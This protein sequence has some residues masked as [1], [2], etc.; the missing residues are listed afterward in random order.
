MAYISIAD[1]DIDANSPITESLMTA[2]RDNPFQSDSPLSEYAGASWEALETQAASGSSSLDFT[3]GTWSLYQCVVFVLTGIVP[4]AN[5]QLQVRTST[6]GGSTWDSGTGNYKYL[7]YGYASALGNVA[8][9]SASATEIVLHANNQHTSTDYSL[10]G[11]LWLMNPSG[12][13]YTNCQWQIDLYDSSDYYTY[14]YGAGVRLSAADV[15]GLRFLPTSG[16]IAQ[17]TV[18]S[19]GLVLPS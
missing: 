13:N 14:Q 10:N 12:T 11:A 8:A 2:L 19:Y 5:S 9:S 15:D 7:N 17:G 3:T 16:N 1:T 4:S 18:S 6:D